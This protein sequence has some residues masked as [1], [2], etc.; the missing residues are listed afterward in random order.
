MPDNG[1]QADLPFRQVAQHLP[2]PCWISDAVGR[3]LWVNDAW[4]AYTGKGPDA[5]AGEG[6]ASLHDPA[7][8]PEVRR[9]WAQ[10]MAAGAPDEMVFPL[11][12][13]DGG[14]R[15]FHTRVVPLKDARGAIT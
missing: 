14:F 3:I 2:V 11:R 9:R 8:L 15:P 7:V 4:R 12:G 5:L 6:L 13:Q 10:A 1:N